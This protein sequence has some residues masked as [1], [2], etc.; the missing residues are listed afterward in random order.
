MGNCAGFGLNSKFGVLKYRTRPHSGNFSCISRYLFA[1]AVNS[2][3]SLDHPLYKKR[4]T[5]C[6]LQKQYSTPYRTVLLQK[7]TVSQLVKKFPFN[8]RTGKF[9]P[10]FQ[11]TKLYQKLYQFNTHNFCLKPV[12]HIVRPLLLLPAALFLSNL[13]SEMIYAF[14]KHCIPVIYLTHSLQSL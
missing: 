4:F 12:L 2:V 8:S 6:K 14:L 10:V 1:L 7:L 3:W 11:V 5:K 9:I 13:P